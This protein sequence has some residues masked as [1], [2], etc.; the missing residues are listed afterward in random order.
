MVKQLPVSKVAGSPSHGGAFM[1]NRRVTSS[2]K[3]RLGGASGICR[4]PTALWHWELQMSFLASREGV[5]RVCKSWESILLQPMDGGCISHHT[6]PCVDE[7][8][9]RRTQHPP[10][11]THPL[12]RV[13]IRVS[14]SLHRQRMSP[15]QPFPFWT[16]PTLQNHFFLGKESVFSTHRH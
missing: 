8:L 1:N 16:A 2:Y 5:L 12:S 14:P 10:E 4:D 6:Q 15:R 13:F 7:G 3:R 11:R 9:Y